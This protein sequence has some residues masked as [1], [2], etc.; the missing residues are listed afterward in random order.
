[1]P[2]VFS[3]DRLSRLKGMETHQFNP[4]CQGVAL[5]LDRLSRLKGME[6]QVPTDTLVKTCETLDRLSRLKGMETAFII[7][8][9]L[10]RA[11]LWIGFPV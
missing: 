11:T 4:L 9:T 10:I 2:P 6:T 5:P 7:V 3:L 8:F 1:M